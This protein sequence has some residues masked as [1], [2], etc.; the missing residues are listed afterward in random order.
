MAR[1][2]QGDA[3]REHRLRDL[4][5]DNPSVL[6]VNELEPSFGRLFTVAKE[7]NL[8]GSSRADT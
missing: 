1:L 8:L 7:L 4:I 5:H 3:R 2:P 6:P